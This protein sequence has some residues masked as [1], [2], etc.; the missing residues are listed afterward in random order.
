[1][2]EREKKS[3]KARESE[4]ERERERERDELQSPWSIV[5]YN[6]GIG[7]FSAELSEPATRPNASNQEN[8]T[9]K[10]ARKAKLQACWSLSTAGVLRS[11]EVEDCRNK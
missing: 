1:M 4:R 10:Q 8:E 6:L 11:E 5:Q 9:A 7:S 2:S 3:E